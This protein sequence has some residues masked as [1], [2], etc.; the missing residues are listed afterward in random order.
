M[1]EVVP[2][3]CSE[4]IVQAIKQLGGNAK[5]TIYP[6]VGHNSWTQTYDNPELYEWLL[7][8]SLR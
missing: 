5:L 7:Q 6:G 4:R 2:V 8:H 3:D 1:D